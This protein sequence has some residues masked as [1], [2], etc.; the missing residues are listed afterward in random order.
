MIYVSDCGNE[1]SEFLVALHEAYEQHACEK[2][3]ITQADVDRW[4]MAFT[5]EGEPGEDP[6][7]PYHK[8]HMAACAVERLACELLGLTMEQHEAN[9]GGITCTQ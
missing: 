5:G 4:D 9:L 2:A 1:D 7:A 3:G 6:N 8:E